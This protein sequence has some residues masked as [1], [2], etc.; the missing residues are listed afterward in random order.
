MVG[1]VLDYGARDPKVKSM[2]EKKGFTGCQK[3]KEVKLAVVVVRETTVSSIVGS[4]P[5]WNKWTE[6]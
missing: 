5:D 4:D 3:V 2:R 6:F 1:C